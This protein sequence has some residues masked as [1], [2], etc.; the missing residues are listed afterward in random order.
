[1]IP[2]RTGG[3]RGRKNQAGQKAQGDER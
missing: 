2:E 1:M 3:G